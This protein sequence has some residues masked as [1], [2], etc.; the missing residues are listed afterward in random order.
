MYHHIGSFFIEITI[1]IASLSEKLKDMIL[2]GRNN[3]IHVK[4]FIINK[5]LPDEVDGYFIR[6]W[7]KHEVKYVRLINETF[8]KQQLIFV[9]WFSQDIISENQLELFSEYLQEG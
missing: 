2:L 8:D 3:N 4:T 5:V 7:K 1:Y 6:E 9:P